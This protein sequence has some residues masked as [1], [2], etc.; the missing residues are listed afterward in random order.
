MPRVT[1]VD[2]LVAALGEVTGAIQAT[3][4]RADDV[5][6]TH[7]A[8]AR[9]SEN[10]REIAQATAHTFVDVAVPL[11]AEAGQEVSWIVAAGTR[12]KNVDVTAE[13]Q[14]AV[15]HASHAAGGLARVADQATDAYVNS[16]IQIKGLLT[17]LQQLGVAVQEADGI[18]DLPLY[19]AQRAARALVTKLDAHAPLV[20]EMVRR[21][22]EGARGNP[23]VGGDASLRG[24]CTQLAVALENAESEAEQLDR[25]V[26]DVIRRGPE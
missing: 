13:V 14:G 9:A 22:A 23:A 20:P 25:A 3:Q 8:M 12:V 5:L 15:T 2:R 1:P 11:S 17:W 16:Q 26:E 18:R 10:L 21:A 24:A 4:N 6:R 7:D 19:R